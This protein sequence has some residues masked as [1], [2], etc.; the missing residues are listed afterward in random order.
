MDKD[1]LKYAYAALLHDVGKFYQRTEVSSSLNGEEKAY[2][3][4]AKVG[5]YQTHVHSG[6]TYRF[7][8]K[9]LQSQGDTEIAS[10]SHHIDCVDRMDEVIQKADRIAS[11][12]DRN[13]ENY[14]IVS[15]YEKR[16]YR[17]ITSR[18][19][20][21]MSEINFGKERENAFFPLGTIDKISHPDK[22]FVPLSVKESI[23]EYKTLFSQFVDE[24][25]KEGLLLGASVTPYQFNRMYALLYKYTTLIP[26]STYET[27]RSAVS[28]FDHLKL[29]SAIASCLY[30]N[31][32][33]DFYMM[34]F[35]I[36][37]IQKF[38][39]QITEGKDT[40]PKLTKSL[41]GRSAF[42]AI[43]TNAIT[44]AVLNEFQLTQANIIFNTGGGAVILLPYLADTEQRVAK[45][46][47]GIIESLY[48]KFNTN[49]T[50]VYAIE[51]L[52]K[53]ELEL[54][55]S[56]KALA[57]KTKLDEEKHR[58][59]VHIMD[60]DFSYQSLDNP[61]ICSMCGDYPS[62]VGHYCKHCEMM[63]DISE[64]YTQNQE[65]SIWYDFSESRHGDIDLGFVSITFLK[66]EDRRLIKQTDY[67]YVDA[68][69]HFEYGNVKMIANLVP[70]NM[71][72]ENI[73]ET[74]GKEYGDQKLG[75]LKMDVDNLGAIFAF[76]LKQNVDQ[77]V[78]LQRSLS[79]YLTLSRFMELFFSLRLKQICMD[80][81]QS[82]QSQ[83][84]NIF[85][86]NYAGGDDLVIMGPVYG[87]IIL[88]QK[89]REEFKAYVCNPNITLSAGIHIQ[90]PSKPIRFGVQTADE[91]LEMSKSFSRNGKIVKDAITIMDVT[92]SFD[93]FAE[94]LQQVEKYRQ[95]IIQGK[96]SRTG[97][98][99]IMSQ[100]QVD[101]I[102]QFYSLI[103]RIQYSILRQVTDEKVRV[104]YIKEITQIKEMNE[105]NYFVLIM[106]LVILFT[107]EGN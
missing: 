42:V 84:E 77:E 106:K 70:Q 24:V 88:S 34:E 55:K 95:Y 74:L 98:Y 101:S 22:D 64:K 49:L 1:F 46:C 60:E 40:K 99:T 79:K 80:V 32:T 62:E 94:L 12:V 61:N 21:I 57:L 4:Y 29:T 93:D 5:N 92:V 52:D 10:S 41:R 56:E 96:I 59:F 63:I 50:F 91:A 78:T 33:E 83:Y 44:Y 43:L 107:R 103:P 104:E 37:G 81:S 19:S 66:K 38:I 18:L 75:I 58:K 67:F 51:K 82:L 36:S 31:N 20:S 17:Y 71:T 14:D 54:F 11:S 87:I 28:L 6:Y 90:T 85:Y 26:S 105:L 2:L 53:K 13:D 102:E 47:N 97:F 73:V 35:D 76:G 23:Q 86:I 100:I 45:L 69:N 16:R 68:L 8:E 15:E 39:Y 9:Y 89:I 30:Y 65:M 27:N 3:P 48:E 7:F 25:Q 72:F